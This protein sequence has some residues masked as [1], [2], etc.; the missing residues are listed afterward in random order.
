MSIR[1]AEK[2]GVSEFLL[3]EKRQEHSH[4]LERGSLLTE[5][6]RPVFLEVLS[7]EPIGQSLFSRCLHDSNHRRENQRLLRLFTTGYSAGKLEAEIQIQVAE[8]PSLLSLFF[9]Q[10]DLTDFSACHA[11][12][13]WFCLEFEKSFCRALYI[14]QT[15]LKL[16]VS[17][18]PLPSKLW[19]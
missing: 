11:L 16:A 9:S 2:Q 19:D 13:C 7:T 5:G 15:G 14:D 1:C 17:L 8:I 10:T 6:I 18:L 12:V 3:W 4:S